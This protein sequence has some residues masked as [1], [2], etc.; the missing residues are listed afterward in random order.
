MQE[1]NNRKIVDDIQSHYNALDA[2]RTQMQNVQHTV[3]GEFMAQRNLV[4]EAGQT[5]QRA[6]AQAIQANAIAEAMRVEIHSG[7]VTPRSEVQASNVA[8]DAKLQSLMNVL[9]DER[10]RNEQA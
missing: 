10:D 9:S 1:A 5:A 8:F 6:M 3:E 4:D 2:T 7:N